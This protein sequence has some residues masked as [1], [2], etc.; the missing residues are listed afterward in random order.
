M[1]HGLWILDVVLAITSFMIAAKVIFVL[2]QRRK[3]RILG[4]LLECEIECDE[5]ASGER[6]CDKEYSSPV[7]ACQ[8]ET[9]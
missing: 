6:S 2:Q 4:S 9:K 1:L 3:S 5:D 8:Q 7:Q